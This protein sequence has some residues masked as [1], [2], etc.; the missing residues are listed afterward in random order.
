MGLMGPVLC[1]PIAY[2]YSVHSLL[3]PSFT[4]SPPPHPRPP[5]RK[6]QKPPNG[7]RISR[8]CL[9]VEQWCSRIVENLAEMGTGHSW[10]TVQPTTSI[11]KR[12]DLDMLCVV[13]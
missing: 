8:G 6:S 12:E 4:H 13:P 10:G 1:A 2:R 11:E 3:S 5:R 9:L 7:K